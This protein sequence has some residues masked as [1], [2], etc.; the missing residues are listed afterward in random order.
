MNEL[1][2]INRV[3]ALSTIIKS[4]FTCVVDFE[5]LSLID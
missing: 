5:K 3:P 1:E 2:N 4:Y